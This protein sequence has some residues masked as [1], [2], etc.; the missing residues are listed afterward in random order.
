MKE[1]EMGGECGTHGRNAY[2]NFIGKPQR[3][4]DLVVDGRLLFK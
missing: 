4:R 1:N 2:K 3:K